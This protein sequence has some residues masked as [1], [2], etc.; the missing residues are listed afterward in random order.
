MKMPLEDIRIIDLT[1]VWFG[2]W[3]TM[4]MAYLGAEV[5]RIE[6]PWGAIDRLAEGALFGGA[7]YTFHH[8]NLNKK[9]LTLNLKDPEG[10]E[11]FKELVKKADVVIQNFS[12]GTMEKLGLEYEVLKELNPGRIYAALSGYG[13]Y[14]PYRKWRAFASI[15]E[16][17]SGHTKQTGERH[18]P[19]G[20]PVQIAQA[21]ADLG[22]G[23]MAAMAVIAALRYRDK[24]GI[25]QMIDV[26]QLD[27]MVAYNTAITGY[28]LSGLKPLE[29]REKYPR[30]RGAGGLFKAKDDGWIQLAAFGPR[31]L[32]RIVQHLGVELNDISREMIED[33]VAKMTRDE[34]VKLFTGIGL[35]CAPVYHIDETI[36]DAH[37]NARDMFME[38]VHPKAG[39]IKLIKFPLKFSETQ[40]EFK[41]P[42]PLLGEHNREVLSGIMGYDDNKIKELMQKGIISYSN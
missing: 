2:P 29:L 20:P 34:A 26:A 8:L 19:E 5:I 12:P 33:R 1:H 38:V 35:P 23:T 18:D 11:I 40:P 6:P 22:P 28:L 32:D 21:Y 25:G 9:D 3:A 15:I 41:T 31:A 42:A 4:M 16:A 30:G 10:L 36:T 37:V 7:S 24:T 13:H 27:C 14:G 17:M 39:K